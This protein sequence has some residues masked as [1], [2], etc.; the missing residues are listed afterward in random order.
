VQRWASSRHS[1][2]GAGGTTSGH[3]HLAAT[4]S[5]WPS[6]WRRY[7]TALGVDAARE[8]IH[9][10]AGRDFDPELAQVFLTLN[11]VV[12]PTELAFPAEPT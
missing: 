6:Y 8:E 4:S 5:S 12:E 9:A 11:E 7:R 10:K 3:T 2:P 1:S